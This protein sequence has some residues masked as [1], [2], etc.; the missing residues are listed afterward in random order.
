H[1]PRIHDLQPQAPHEMQVVPEEHAVPTAG[2]GGTGH[3]D[4]LGGRADIGR[5]QAVAH[6]RDCRVRPMTI[7]VGGFGAGGRMGATGAGAGDADLQ[8][9]AAV[10]PAHAGEEVEGV[11]IA[12]GPDA[13]ADVVEVAVDFTALAAAR[14]NARWCADHGVHAVIG[15]TGFTPDD[16]DDLNA[17]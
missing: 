17:A 8:L 9:V 15:T 4:E 7:R 5:T 12:P 10:D 6:G 3:P 11:T 16:I 2:L 14:L 1:H 13:M